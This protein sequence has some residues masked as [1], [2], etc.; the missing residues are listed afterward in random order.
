MKTQCVRCGQE[1]EVVD[2]KLGGL[3]LDCLVVQD[4]GT[5]LGKPTHYEPRT[6]PEH[7]C[8]MTQAIGLRVVRDVRPR[9]FNEKA[10]TGHATGL[11]FRPDRWQAPWQ[12]REC[13]KIEW[14]DVE[15]V[16]YEEAG[17]E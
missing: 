4:S 8:C 1:I 3:C 11:V 12:C 13:G 5:L 9:P 2:A 17:L 10:Q 15:I 6:N 16:S 14:K 7:V